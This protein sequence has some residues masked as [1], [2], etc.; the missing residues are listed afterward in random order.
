MRRASVLQGDN[1]VAL[2]SLG[3]IQTHA[4]KLQAAISTLSSAI[5]K[6]P[7]NFQMHYYL[8]VALELTLKA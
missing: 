7:S 8:G 2:L 6:F 5:K 4:G 1:S 3:I